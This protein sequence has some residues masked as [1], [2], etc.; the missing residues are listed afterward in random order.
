MLKYCAFLV[1]IYDTET[2]FSRL[3]YVVHVASLKLVLQ[4]LMYFLCVYFLAKF[5]YCCIRLQR[6]TLKTSSEENRQWSA[7]LCLS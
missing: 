7:T 6:I 2:I 1:L 5:Y 4:Q 3:S